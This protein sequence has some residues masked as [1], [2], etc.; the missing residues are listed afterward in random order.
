MITV[1]RTTAA[2]PRFVNLIKELDKDLWDRYQPYQ[3]KYDGFNKVDQSAR[4]VVALADTVPVGCGCFRPTEEPAVIEIKR[5]FVAT[6]RRGQGIAQQVLR[7][8][9]S[10]ATEEGFSTAK[11]E[12]GNKQPEAIR[13]YQKAG[14]KSI[15]LYGPYVGMETSICLGKPLI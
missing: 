5:M 13:L 11:L 2:D 15:D 10:W 6:E 3:A 12:T 14:Y 7:E 9:E 8:L 4:V 1:T